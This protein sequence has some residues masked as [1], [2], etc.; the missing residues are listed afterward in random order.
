MIRDNLNSLS[1]VQDVHKGH[2]ALILGSGYSLEKIDFEEIS[3]EDIL[4]SCNQ[5]VT[6]L[7]HCDYFCMT[8]GAIPE[9]N[10]FP[11]GADIT[12]KIVF[13][14]GMSFLHLPAVIEQYEKIKNKS[15]FFNRRYHNTGNVD[16]NLNDGLL[17]DG[18]DVVHVIA[19]LA[20]IMGCS[21]IILAGVDLN[22]DN[23]KKYCSNTEFK[24]KI[25]W[26]MEE[27]RPAM[28]PISKSPSG[29]GD[30]NLERSFKVWTN[31]KEV[32]KSIVFLNASPEG[33][34]S[35]LFETILLPLKK[36]D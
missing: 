12:N 24:E 7:K 25:V 14:S 23:G 29:I 21:P 33:R 31:I 36:Q 4:F 10:F 22:Y 28:W 5:S 3:K 8:D 1:E 6:M 27:K 20:H 15:Y 32:N 35:D 30:S 16:F 9:A 19:H 17:I 34:L 18:N 13:C 2:R 11:Y 26:S